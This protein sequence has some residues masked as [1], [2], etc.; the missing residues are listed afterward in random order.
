MKIV[1][2]FPRMGYSVDSK[3]LL[4]NFIFNEFYF[5]LHWLF[6][7]CELNFPKHILILS[8]DISICWNCIGVRCNIFQYRRYYWQGKFGSWKIQK[9]LTFFWNVA[10][11]NK[12][13]HFLL[14]KEIGFAKSYKIWQNHKFKVLWLLTLREI[15]LHRP[16][17]FWEI[18]IS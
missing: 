13:N 11:V 16:S 14:R 17:S 7:S 9:N 4:L 5:R 8:Y 3:S 15:Y 10:D 18:I 1:T 6:H 12:R 2:R